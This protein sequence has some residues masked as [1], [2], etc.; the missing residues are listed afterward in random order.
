MMI[1]SIIMFIGIYFLRFIQ[2][3][4]VIILIL[5]IIMGVAIYIGFSILTKNECYLYLLNII[6]N[7]IKKNN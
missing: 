5:Q 7:K 4:K 2:I 6:K 1:P 3:N